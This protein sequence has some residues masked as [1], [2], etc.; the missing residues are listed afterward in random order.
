[1]SCRNQ[2]ACLALQ[3]SKTAVS[4]LMR[5]AWRRSAE[6]ARGSATKRFQAAICSRDSRGSAWTR[7]FARADDIKAVVVDHDAGR[8][9]WAAP[10]RD[11][12]KVEKFLHLLGKQRCRRLKLVSCDVATWITVAVA[13][14]CRTPASVTTRC[15]SS[16]ATD[17]LGEI[18]REVWS[19]ARRP[20]QAC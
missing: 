4:K 6:S 13:D 1:M 10:G 17:T 12:K 14:R 8:L 5:I 15:T 16:R 9:V 18:C 2:V 20:G 11:R 3:A 7:S 19:D